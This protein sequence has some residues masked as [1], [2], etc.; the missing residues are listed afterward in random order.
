MILYSNR[1]WIYIKKEKI[2]LKRK[3]KAIDISSEKNLNIKLKDVGLNNV[4]SLN[5]S[6]FN[7]YHLNITSLSHEYDKIS[8]AMTTHNEKVKIYQNKFKIA[9]C[10][11]SFFIK[12][13]II[14]KVKDIVV[15]KDKN[16]IEYNYDVKESFLVYIMIDSWVEFYVY[17]NKIKIT[18]SEKNID[19]MLY[20]TSRMEELLNI[21]INNKKCVIELLDEEIYYEL[22]VVYK[23]KDI[24]SSF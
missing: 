21:I 23:D 16:K 19:W 22:S 2:F 15:K 7:I 9:Y 18:F 13:P 12:Y 17:K 11:V 20:K 10:D 3:N 24:T 8:W 4:K 1:G 6:E 5:D 14:F